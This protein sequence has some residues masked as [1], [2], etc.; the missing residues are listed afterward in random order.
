MGFLIRLLPDVMGV[1]GAAAVLYGLSRW[2]VPLAC[3]VGGLAGVTIAV[4]QAWL[5]GRRARTKLP[6]GR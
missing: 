2:S 1:L 6:E 5:E 3:V 4:R